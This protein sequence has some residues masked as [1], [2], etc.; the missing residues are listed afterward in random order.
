MRERDELRDRLIFLFENP[1]SDDAGEKADAVLAEIERTHV[2][3]EREF[4][5]RLA[6]A[7]QVSDCFD[8]RGA[9]CL[10]SEDW[11]AIERLL[12]SARIAQDERNRGQ[13]TTAPGVLRT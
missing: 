4:A 6:V 3:L 1:P 5:R 8:D 12:R 2:L 11:A 9:P 10:R 7:A 13:C